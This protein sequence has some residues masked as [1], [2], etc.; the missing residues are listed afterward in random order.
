MLGEAMG[1][2]LDFRV[3]QTPWLLG[4]DSLAVQGQAALGQGGEG[5]LH[6]THFRIRKGGSEH[7]AAQ[8]GWEEWPCP[9]HS[10]PCTE[11][12]L[13]GRWGRCEVTTCDCQQQR[14]RRRG[15]LVA[16]QGRVTHFWGVRLSKL[17]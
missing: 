1:R 8:R 9:R 4:P 7:S 11:V 13:L 14:G 16:G 10:V 6:L 5:A 3:A 12:A 15:E 2:P 17:L